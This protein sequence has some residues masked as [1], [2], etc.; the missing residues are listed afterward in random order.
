ME[1]TRVNSKSSLGCVSSFCLTCKTILEKSKINEDKC[2]SND[3]CVICKE[4]CKPKPENAQQ[5]PI[6]TTAHVSVSIH[7][8]CDDCTEHSDHS[9][10]S[11]VHICGECAKTTD[12]K[13]T[14]ESLATCSICKKTPTP[15]NVEGSVNEVKVCVSKTECK[16]CSAENPQLKFAEVLERMR[17]S[18]HFND[19]VA[20]LKK[21]KTE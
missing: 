12:Y 4:A 3:Y 21:S 16:L 9:S 17:Q 13:A 6:D 11:S 14:C 19:D 7:D 10:C 8:V 18:V 5:K 15:K 20:K 1:V 2:D